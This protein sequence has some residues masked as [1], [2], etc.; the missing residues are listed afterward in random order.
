MAK[1]RG[2]K[3]KPEPKRSEIDKAVEDYLANGGEIE[4]IE[5][6]PELVKFSNPK[7]EAD[8][9]LMGE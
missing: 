8:E 9:F 6:L 3:K 7:N 5:L 2:G 1:W 4:K